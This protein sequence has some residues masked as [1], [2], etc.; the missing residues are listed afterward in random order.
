MPLQGGSNHCDWDRGAGKIEY[1]TGDAGRADGQASGGVYV[2]H[3][4]AGW[5]EGVV[6]HD[7]NAWHNANAAW[8]DVGAAAAGH[9]GE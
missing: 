6:R 8:D 7:V 5:I 3:S 2:E 4:D 1:A 9:G